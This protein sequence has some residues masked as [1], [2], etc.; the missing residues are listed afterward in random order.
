MSVFAELNIIFFPFQTL[1]TMK[2]ET[3]VHISQ[4]LEQ[5]SFFLLVSIIILVMLT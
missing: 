2:F 1:A 5:N 4:N 3:L